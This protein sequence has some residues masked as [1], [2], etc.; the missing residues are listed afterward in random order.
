LV[1]DQ[2]E[3]AQTAIV[4]FLRQNGYFQAQVTPSTELY[5][6]EGL[7]N[8]IFQVR[9]GKRAKI[10]NV[11]V[12]GPPSE[13]SQRLL[14]ATRSLRA[15]AIGGSLKPGKLY[16]R[17]RIRIAQE[18][19]RRYLTKHQFLAHKIQL[20]PPQYHPES[21][22]ADLT[23]TVSEG[24]K[25]DI[26]IKGAR[27]SWISFLRSRREKKIIP[28]YEEGTFDQDLVDEGKRNLISYF[29][30]KGYFA[31]QV[32]TA[33]Q[34]QSEK[35]SL[36]YDVVKG[37]RH[38]VDEITFTGNKHLSND[39]LLSH[40]TVA[41]K[42]FF[43]KGKFSDKLLRQ[44]AN[45]IQAVYR[46]NGFEQVSVQPQAV[47]K[48]QKVYVSFQITE[49]PQTRVETVRFEGN[50]K[51]GVGA[52]TPRGGF[53]EHTGAPFSTHK[54]S[55]DRGHILSVYLD[56]GYL[57]A[58]VK[59]N[60]SRHPNDPQKVD[61]TYVITEGQQV[62][63]QNVAILGQKNTR[64]SLIAST[65]NL[66]PESPLSQGGLLQAES[67][68]YNLGIFDWAS[69]GPRR[70][71]ANQDFEE[72]VVKVHESRRN[73][74][75][76]GFGVEVSRRGANAPTGTVA[77][78]GL[79]T[80]GLGGAKIP[81]SEETFFS[82]RGTV[83]FTRHNLRGLAETGSVTV[84]LSRLDQRVIATYSDPQFRGSSWSTLFSVSAERSTENPL[85]AARLGE[86][87][88]QFERALDRKKTLTA[89]FRYRFA[90]TSLN[91]LLV[92]ELVLPEDRS[93]RLSTFSATLIR[94]TRDKP[95]DA[96][97]GFYQ[98][99]DFGITG[100][101]IGAS[102]DFSRFLT[103][104]AYYKEI[105]GGIVWANSVRLG[106]AKAFSGD[107]LPTSERFFSGGGTTLRGFPVNGAGPQRI[108][109]FC[110]DQNDPN[111]CVNVNVPVGGNQLFI[112]N[113]ELRAPL[114]L[115]KNLG[116]VLFYDGGN[117]YQAI[118][119]RQFIDNYTNTVGVGIRY[120]T[121]VGPVRFDIGRNLNPVTGFR[122]T[123]FIV[124]LGQAF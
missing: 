110:T 14:A 63:I 106:L 119:L 96:H 38:K 105:G 94:D 76:Y 104:T 12:Q 102:A 95:L 4:G 47:N 116:G 73:S 66:H 124:T 54:V 87:S 71:I 123:Q 23:F 24:P 17:R 72:A 58:D 49:G 78:P 97:K 75:T 74:I 100:R 108:V 21:N 60:V 51:F 8:V 111:T 117:V 88:Y 5:E 30:S 103:Q 112:F 26:G 2:I 36:V 115:I 7:A 50:N 93:V 32:R 10:G 29:Q 28:I 20:G 77:V 35:I 22:R 83:E 59:S 122:A 62:R 61:I 45:N 37:R 120:N 85:F 79:P 68:L 67:D 65:A 40:V 16:T 41:R 80:V 48:G 44:S 109:P 101:K 113:S 55:E 53:N 39:E 89:Q 82:P 64:R 46:D 11:Q 69:V 99:A 70:P 13:E 42:H 19:I 98:T 92:P 86:V 31:V 57:S 84:L 91:D 114:P 15:L 25:V 6:K 9:L 1:E 27:L 18:L 52:F 34:R 81:S 3:K 56:R 90:R 107:R 121:P 118:N 33:V 43:S